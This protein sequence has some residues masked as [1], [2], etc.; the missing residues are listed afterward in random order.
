VEGNFKI[1]SIALDEGTNIF[2]V[3]IKDVAGNETY[4]ESKIKVTYSPNSNV[5]GDAVDDESLPV[6]AGEESIMKDFFLGNILV[7]IFGILA[8]VGVTA[9]TVVVYSRYKRN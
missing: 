4:L 8:L 9:S 7:V 5:N 6:A 2:N 3:L 1:A